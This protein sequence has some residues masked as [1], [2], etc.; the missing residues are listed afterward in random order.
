MKTN[1]SARRIMKSRSLIFCLAIAGLVAVELSLGTSLMAHF[2][3]LTVC[4]TDGAQAPNVSLGDMFAAS[5]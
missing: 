4:Q 1:P 2:G 5:H 3:Q